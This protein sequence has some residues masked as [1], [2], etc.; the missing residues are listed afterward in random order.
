MSSKLL[1][2]VVTIGFVC[3]PMAVGRVILIDFGAH[4]SAAAPAVTNTWNTVD[5]GASQ[6]ILKDSAGGVTSARISAGAFVSTSY[7]SNEWKFASD[8][9]DK[10]ASRDMLCTPNSTGVTATITISGLPANLPVK[11]ELISSHSSPYT[12]TLLNA[13]YSINGVYFSPQVLEDPGRMHAYTGYVDSRVMRWANLTADQDGQLRLLAAPDGE[14][15]RGAINA[16]KIELLPEP[17]L[18]L[19]AGALATGLLQRTRR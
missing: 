9:I 17:G 19:I 6:Q 15:K 7:I 2:V 18:G 4:A 5:A 1:L 11:V 12:G 3:A 8:W 16:M 13:R 14:Y 10:A